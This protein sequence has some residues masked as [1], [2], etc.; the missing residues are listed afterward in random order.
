MLHILFQEIPTVK[1]GFGFAIELFFIIFSCLCWLFYDESPST[2]VTIED[3]TT[4][5]SD[6]SEVEEEFL[7]NIGKHYCKCV[8]SVVEGLTLDE[9][10]KI[11]SRLKALEIIS[12]NIK[13]NGKGIGKGFLIG[14]IKSKVSKCHETIGSALTEILGKTIG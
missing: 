1:I 13:L 8:E 7:A 9:A 5:P 14:L 4:T 3:V 2:S 12:P 11:A 10:R 6:I